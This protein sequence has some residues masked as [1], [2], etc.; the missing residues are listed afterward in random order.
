MTLEQ[1][2]DDDYVTALRAGD[3]GR[4]ATLRLLRAELKNAT[5]ANGG[6]LDDEAV[7]RLL[8]QQAKQR[9][10]SA[11]QYGAAGRDDLVANEMAELA[12]IEDYLPRQLAPEEIEEAAR[13]LIDEVGATG[14]ADTGRVMG[15]LM[16]Q[17]AGQADGKQVSEIV[18]RL[19]AG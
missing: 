17:L 15:P 7:T 18:R 14:P 4:K 11:A 9:R 8:A 19:L 1:R 16:A 12:V 6:P 3:D 10:D 2:I 5:I 13:R